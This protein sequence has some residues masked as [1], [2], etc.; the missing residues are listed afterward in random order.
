MW[1]ADNLALLFYRSLHK[2]K[3]GGMFKGKYFLKHMQQ[4][5]RDQ[6][7]LPGSRKQ[8]VLSV[9]QVPAP[10]EISP[11]PEVPFTA[12]KQDPPLPPPP[13]SSLLPPQVPSPPPEPKPPS[14]PEPSD[15]LLQEDASNGTTYDVIDGIPLEPLRKGYKHVRFA[16]WCCDD[17]TKSDVVSDKVWAV[18][19]KTGTQSTVGEGMTMYGKRD[20]KLL[21][22]ETASK[23]KDSYL[24][25][26]V[27]TKIQKGYN[28]YYP[29]VE[30]LGKAGYLLSLLDDS[31]SS[32]DDD[33]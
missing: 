15:H 17:S 22:K 14:L 2:K 31:S 20:G 7:T 28:L 6:P 3:G 29:Y 26:F 27:R 33:Q 13:Q 5:K 30:R 32:D 1:S 4:R 18:L 23:Y 8:P 10:K 21:Y 24:D 25:G 11:E 12:M 16:G 19:T 9:P